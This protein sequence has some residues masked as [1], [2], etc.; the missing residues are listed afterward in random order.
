MGDKS[1]LK[2][3][4][5]D[6]KKNGTQRDD[7]CRDF[8]KNICNRGS[9]C[10]FYHPEEVERERAQD[11]SGT[12]QEFNFCIDFQNR[13]C[14]R[15][16][17]RFIHAH[18]DD[19]ER[20]KST[21]EVTLNLARAIAAVHTGDTINGIPFCKEFQTGIC[22]R[23]SSRCRYWHVNVEEERDRR[24][25]HQRGLPL[26]P[27]HLRAP[28]A[29][30]VPAL[31]PPYG[32]SSPYGAGAAPRRPIP[33]GGG[34]EAYDA[35]IAAAG[36]KRARYEA[37][38][39]ANQDYARELERKNAELAKENEGLKRELQRERERYEDLYALFRQRGTAAAPAP[40]PGP[41][42]VSSGGA[43]G[44]A[45]YGAPAGAAG[46][47]PGAYYPPSV[48]TNWTSAASRSHWTQ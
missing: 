18:R 19:V 23:G 4:N 15:D 26:G 46:A 27:G 35:M 24:R 47:N 32:F 40:V 31:P 12:K 7:V 44:S 16:N 21:G 14:Q 2:K 42:P 1:D 10:K 36:A 45:S 41:E 22:S 30:A 6:E 43:Y 9:R 37:A 48:Q 20:Y 38:D 29:G 11:S 8:L 33:Y 39:A 25:R 34:G 17:C 28:G 13:G 5:P 3:E